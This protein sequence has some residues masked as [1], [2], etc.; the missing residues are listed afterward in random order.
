MKRVLLGVLIASSS[1]SLVA[2]D[3]MEVNGALKISTLGYGV[4]I[5]TPINSRYSARF[6]VNGLS[7]S[8]T[9]TSD[10][11][12]Y[13]GTLDLLTLGVLVDA[14]PFENN[15]RL[16]SGLYYNGNKFNGTVTPSST[17]SVDINGRTYTASDLGRL[18]SDITFNK[19][20][21][22][23]G[24]GWGN[25]A[26]DTGWGFTFD[27]GVLYQGAGT[28]NLNAEVINS[29]LASQIASDIAQEE[30][31]I[32]DDLSKF[33]FYPVLSLGVNYTF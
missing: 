30:Q 17:V 16:S 25:D 4:D 2:D 33:K 21:P 26:H 9:Q 10:G 29:T 5:S 6:N 8:D 14:Y 1:M 15:F 13:S 20:A 19:I 7:Y 11:N 18:N 31:N 23:F 24:I 3:K 32:N 22:Y 28:A 12:T 27:L